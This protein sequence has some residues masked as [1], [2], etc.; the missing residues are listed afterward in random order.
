M[1]FG[2]LIYLFGAWPLVLATFKVDNTNEQEPVI[3][4]GNGVDNSGNSMN[5]AVIN[6]SDSST[7][8][9]NTSDF[10]HALS[11]HIIYG[12]NTNSIN[13]YSNNNNDYFAKTCH[14]CDI[15]RVDRN[16]NCFAIQNCPTCSMMVKLITFSATVPLTTSVAPGTAT[17]APVTHVSG[18]VKF[19]ICPNGQ[20]FASAD[21]AAPFSNLT[22]DFLSA[23]NT[24]RMFLKPTSALGPTASGQ[25]TP[26]SFHGSSSVIGVPTVHLAIALG[27]ATTI[28]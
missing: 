6:H 13:F 17:M 26:I 21:Q 8:T 9:I 15:V 1:K 7:N 18:R 19:N 20:C 5:K 22:G 23:P 14:S 2:V 27:F 3:S 4:T 16:C 12:F 11:G 28:L 10:S 24:T 25:N